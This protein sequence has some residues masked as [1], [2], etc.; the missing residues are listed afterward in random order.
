[1][2]AMSARWRCCRGTGCAIARSAIT[3]FARSATP[4]QM[5]L[6]QTP[7]SFEVF[8][9]IPVTISGGS[10]DSKQRTNMLQWLSTTNNCVLCNMQPRSSTPARIMT[11]FANHLEVMQSVHMSDVAEFIE[12]EELDLSE[13][14]HIMRQPYFRRAF[15]VEED[16][17]KLYRR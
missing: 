17:Q 13:V 14:L 2:S 1:M 8:F 12:K 9:E 10:S 4:P 5:Q 3:R 11:M 15:R 16:S 6:N 7:R